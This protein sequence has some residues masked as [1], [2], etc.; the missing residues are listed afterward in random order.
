MIKTAIR[1]VFLLLLLAG[2]S[3]AALSVHVIRTPDRIIVIP[4][5]RLGIE[6]TYVDARKWTKGDMANH[7]DLV[8]RVLEA[9]KADQFKYL[10]G[11]D[12][13]GQLRAMLPTEKKSGISP[14]VLLQTPVDF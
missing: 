10:T 7:P 3:V 2:W 5:E 6:D 11:D 13:D 14:D 12:A 1:L 9:G 8:K 4:K